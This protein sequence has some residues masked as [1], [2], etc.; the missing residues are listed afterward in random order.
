LNKDRKVSAQA[1]ASDNPITDGSLAPSLLR[2]AFP[3]SL[4]MGT[5]AL[6]VMADM[7]WVG[8]LG[9]ASVAAVL[10]ASILTMLSF[11]LQLGAQTGSTAFISRFTGAGEWSRARWAALQ[12][13]MLSLSVAVFIGAIY[14]FFGGWFF[15]IALGQ[16]AEVTAL[17]VQ[18]LTP[19]AIGM[20]FVFLSSQAATIL[21]AIGEARKTTAIFLSSAIANIIL[22]PI[23]IEGWLGP[24][25]GVAGAAYAT[26]L[27]RTLGLLLACYLLS[28]KTGLTGRLDLQPR[29]VMP[30]AQFLAMFRIG[31]PRIIQF[32]FVPISRMLLIRLAVSLVLEHDRDA[33][34][35]AF[36]LCLRLEFIS[37]LPIFGLS[38]ASQVFIGQNLGAKQEQRAKRTGWVAAA[39][40]AAYLALITALYLSVPAQLIKPF[41]TVRSSPRSQI[42]D[43]TQQ[44]QRRAIQE[45]IE[46]DNAKVIGYGVQ[47]MKTVSWVLILW[48]M[49]LI[50]N[51]SINGAGDTVFPAIATGL[52]LIPIRY[53]LASLLSRRYGLVG[54]WYSVAITMAVLGLAFI[55]YYHIG[56][57]IRVAE[58]RL[59]TS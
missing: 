37:L 41:L 54:I 49:A 27:S 5:N 39:L 50:L 30:D 15:S 17:G 53:G 42:L 11:S 45:K 55:V 28:K 58:R 21:Q 48:G 10:S 22:D 31:I 20:P 47:Y 59:K 23:L 26:V 56:R 40:S 2:F 29:F 51:S 6:Y 18:Y 44:A 43:S 12:S 32:A 57:W 36:T 33:V 35:A 1:K 13:L 24:A 46:Q 16:S 9:V 38:R 3:L 7:Y 25:F 19:L 4:A 34:S 14:L 52:T 8:G